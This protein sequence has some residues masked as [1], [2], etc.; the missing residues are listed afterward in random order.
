MTMMDQERQRPVSL[1]LYGAPPKGRHNPLAII[2][3]GYGGHNADY[4]FVAEYLVT[5]G[6]VVA[7]IKH[8]ERPGDPPMANSGDLAAQRRPVWQIGADSIGFVVRELSRRGIARSRV[9]P[10]LIGHSNGGDMTMLYATEHPEKISL[11]VSLDNRRMPLPRSKSPRICSIRSSDLAADPGVVPSSREQ[12]ELGMSII[13]VSVKHEDM[14]DG[15]APAEK[16]AILRALET[17]ID[18]HAVAHR[19]QRRRGSSAAH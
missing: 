3:H 11:A 2:S 17:C 4:S 15:G 14:W 10:I 5:K 8:A 7:S 6:Y 16:D 1:L 12:Q 19:V 13:A 18:A 9:K